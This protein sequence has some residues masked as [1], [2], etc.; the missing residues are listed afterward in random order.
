VVAGTPS[1]PY[2]F[3]PQL[4]IVPDELLHEP[5]A[6][7]ILEYLDGYATATEK[8]FLAHKG[9]V[10]ANDYARDSVEKNC[11]GA[12]GARRQSRVENRL[13]VNRGWLAAGVLK[14]IHLAM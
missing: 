12:H 2:V 5:N 14:S 4:G 3:V 8:L 1:H 6:I 7:F 9:P 11:A 13:A 10:L